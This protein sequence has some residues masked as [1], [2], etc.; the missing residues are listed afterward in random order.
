MFKVKAKRVSFVA[1]DNLQVVVNKLKCVDK[2]F[3]PTLNF[4]TLNPCLAVQD[5]MH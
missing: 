1:G 3:V 5:L 2:G 4:K